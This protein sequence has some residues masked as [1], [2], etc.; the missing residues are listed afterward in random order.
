MKKK[1]TKKQPK[2][3]LADSGDWYGLYKDGELVAEDSHLEVNTVLEAL[4]IDFETR[5]VELEDSHF[6]EKLS[7]LKVSE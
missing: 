1:P 6:P 3:V 7:D 5:D 4:G 2:V